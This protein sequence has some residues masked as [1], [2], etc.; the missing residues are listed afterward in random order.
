MV[1]LS[2]SLREKKTEGSFADPSMTLTLL[3][4]LGQ[5]SFFFISAY[6]DESNFETQ[7]L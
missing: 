2:S 4:R 3:S 7:K 6:G 1:D 5:G